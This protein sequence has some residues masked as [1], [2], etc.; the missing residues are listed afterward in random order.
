MHTGSRRKVLSHKKDA[1]HF[2]RCTIPLR[3]R[4]DPD[5]DL[6][7]DQHQIESLIRIQIGN[8]TMLIHTVLTS[9]KSIRLMH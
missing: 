5:W 8:K 3:S 4:F 6:D 9:K 7:P 2:F 1:P